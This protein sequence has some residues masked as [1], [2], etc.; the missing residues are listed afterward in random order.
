MASVGLNTIAALD[1]WT[2]SFLEASCSCCKHERLHSVGERKREYQ[3][4]Y[5]RKEASAGT[6][7]LH[8][9]F[10]VWRWVVQWQI[11]T[12]SLFI[13]FWDERRLGLG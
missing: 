1:T 4:Q 7:Q 3:Y 12:Q 11:G 2:V 5:Q 10:W 6:I 8:T 13:R 9:V